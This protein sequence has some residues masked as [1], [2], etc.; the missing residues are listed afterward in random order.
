MIL[1]Q[2][3]YPRL[4][5]RIYT[6]HTLNQFIDIGTPESLNKARQI[7]QNFAPELRDVK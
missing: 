4:I 5:G 1:V 6:Y 2:R 3:S 7:W